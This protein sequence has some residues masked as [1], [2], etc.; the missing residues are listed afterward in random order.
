VA[1]VKPKRVPWN[2]G[3]KHSEETKAKIRATTREAMKRPDIIAKLTISGHKQRH[4]AETK[5]KISAKVS[6]HRYGLVSSSE[7]RPK[8]RNC[9]FTYRSSITKRWSFRHPFTSQLPSMQP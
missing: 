9:G 2:K 8:Q 1:T 3:L 4:T 6:L 5:A 7:Q